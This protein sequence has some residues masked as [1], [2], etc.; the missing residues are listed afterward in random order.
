MAIEIY[1][2]ILEIT[3]CKL[4]NNYESCNTLVNMIWI[5]TELKI[6][7]NDDFVRTYD[8]D[9]CI[10]SPVS[11]GLTYKYYY[12][13]ILT[14]YVRWAT[15]LLDA[16]LFDWTP[17]ELYI[18]TIFTICCKLTW[19]SFHLRSTISHDLWQCRLINDEL[20]E[21]TVN[22]REI[23]T[24]NLSTTHLFWR[25]WRFWKFWN[26]CFRSFIFFPIDNSTSSDSVWL[27]I[28]D[29]YT[30]HYVCSTE[31]TCIQYLELITSKM[32]PWCWK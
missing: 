6:M 21:T 31:K 27:N 3:F 8:V 29:C 22:L 1:V 32:V 17:S 25:F 24:D 14:L 19:L 2:T 28:W 9:A 4:S 13:A 23:W 5:K 15:F 10:E 20:N 30:H 18:Y 12:G 26:E 7:N 16:L 11:K